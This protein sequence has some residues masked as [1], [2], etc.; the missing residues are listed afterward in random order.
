[1]HKTLDRTEGGEES[2]EPLP[3]VMG[4][5]MIEYSAE[6]L[7]AGATGYAHYGSCPTKR[8]ELERNTTLHGAAGTEA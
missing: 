3:R 2:L 1:M 6:E 7:C 5:S 4:W 8:P